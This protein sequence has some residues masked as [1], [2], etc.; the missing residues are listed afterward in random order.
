MSV[1]ESPRAAIRG[2]MARGTTRYVISRD[3]GVDHSGLRRFLTEGRDIRASKVDALA[4]FLGLELAR[5]KA[6]TRP[7]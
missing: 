3:S 4:E 7:V 6:E 5:K 1:S 2:A